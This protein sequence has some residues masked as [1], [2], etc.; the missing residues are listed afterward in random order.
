MQQK[1]QLKIK[2][3][4]PNA[5]LP[6]YG[7]SGAA[8]FDLRALIESEQKIPVGCWEPKTFRTGLAVEVPDGYVLLIFSR[9]GHGF[10]ND[11]RLSN[12]VGV[13]DSDYRGEILVK[14]AKDSQN[15]ETLWII[16]GMRIAQAMLVKIPKVEF[17]EVSELS[18]TTRGSG[19][20]GSTGA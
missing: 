16:D 9:S 7:S 17:V 4:H 15:S 14:L 1:A 6:Q 8:C 11:T 10:N 20:F 5:K 13:V 18:E 2:R 12:A 19:G 3:V